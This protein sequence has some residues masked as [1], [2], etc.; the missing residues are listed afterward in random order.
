MVAFLEKKKKEWYRLHSY[1][2][3]LSI[4]S[5]YLD[6]WMDFKSAIMVKILLKRKKMILLS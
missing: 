2:F 3:D 4:N 1:L 6:I 5:V